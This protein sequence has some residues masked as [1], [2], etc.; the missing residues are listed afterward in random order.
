MHVATQFS[1]FLVNKPGILASI[2]EE[3]GRAKVNI[4]ALTMM[5]SSEHGV[6]RLVV[7][8]EDECR[9][10]LAKLNLPTTEADVLAVPIP[11]KP[12]AIADVAGKLAAEHI[13]IS[14][15]YVTSGAGPR[16]SALAILKVADMKKAQK[17]LS[18]QPKRSRDIGALGRRPTRKR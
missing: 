8:H 9:A 11:N 3:L 2:C 12:G 13:N 4:E 18:Q 6:L 14:Y 16:G 7:K 17:I 15:A 5:D 1:V 10:V